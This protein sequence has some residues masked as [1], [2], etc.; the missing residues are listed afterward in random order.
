[1][2]VHVRLFV[3][4]LPRNVFGAARYWADQG[5]AYA[6]AL[7]TLGLPFCAVTSVRSGTD[8]G[9]PRSPWYHLA[10]HFVAE[11]HQKS[12]VNVVCGDNGDV[13]G[14]YTVS[15]PNVAITGVQPRHPT[16]AEL[17]SLRLYDTVFCPTTDDM[18]SLRALGVKAFHATPTSDLYLETLRKYAH[19][20]AAL[21]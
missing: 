15:V 17:A 11:V 21:A 8:L 4:A 19:E 10:P 2:P 20:Q 7:E 13:H 18:L 1:M 12:Y 16:E 3:R 14:L 5:L 6:T 9:D